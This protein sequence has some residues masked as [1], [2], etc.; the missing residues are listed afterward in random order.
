MKRYMPRFTAICLAVLLLLLSLGAC[1]SA[2]G[3]E[4]TS[5]DTMASTCTTAPLDTD[6]P[7]ETTI[8]AD[9][10]ASEDDSTNAN[11]AVDFTVQDWDG[12]LVR[13]SDFFGTPIVLNF[14]A[15]WCPPCKAEL[16]DFEAAY[17]KYEGKVIFL[18]VNL[19][20]GDRETTAIAKEFVTSAGYTFPVYF[21]TNYQA[22]YNYGISSIP[23]TYFINAEG[24]AVARA[25]GMISAAQLE[26]GIGMIY[27]E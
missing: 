9:T 24:E 4:F 11:L 16:P 3:N 6:A 22:A 5:T 14:W 23:Q 2:N 19:T 1:T 20:D 15:S 13:L 17:K 18:M 25:T 12:R 21:D 7:A 10:T 27:S 26:Q 8:P